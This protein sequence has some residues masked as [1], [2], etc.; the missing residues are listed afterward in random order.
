MT[1]G[2]VEGKSNVWRELGRLFLGA[3]FCQ[4]R[5][6]T[7]TRTGLGMEGSETRSEMSEAWTIIECAGC[8]PDPNC[9]FPCAVL[10]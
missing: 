1:L 5:T 8:C 9:I 3:K 7:G 4:M 6:G 2:Q 10:R